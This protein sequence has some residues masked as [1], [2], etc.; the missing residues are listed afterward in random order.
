MV[1]FF[2]QNVDQIFEKWSSDQWSN[3]QLVARSLI[4]TINI[5]KNDRMIDWS[6]DHIQ[7]FDRAINDRAISDRQMI[8]R[9]RSISSFLIDDRR[10]IDQFLKNLIDGRMI[11]RS[12]SDLIDSIIW[13]ID[14][15]SD[16][17]RFW[18]SRSCRSRS[19]IV[20]G[21]WE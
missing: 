14:H 8:A 11:D 19:M 12:Y 6:V 7:N 2:Y 16:F 5:W 3:D 10:S 18:R 20:D 1:T 21:P 17:D 15:W 4:V 9:S 13:S